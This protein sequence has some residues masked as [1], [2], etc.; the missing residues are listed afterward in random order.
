MAE[1]GKGRGAGIGF[2]SERGT[3][4]CEERQ[5]EPLKGGVKRNKRVGLKGG[6]GGL[7]KTFGGLIRR[8]KG[9]I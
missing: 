3:E 8:T 2:G 4:S 1:Q 9:G 7:R 6:Q 5:G